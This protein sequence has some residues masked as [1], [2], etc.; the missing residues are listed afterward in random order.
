MAVDSALLQRWLTRL[1]DLPQLAL[2]TDYP[3]PSGE[4]ALSMVEARDERQLDHRTGA[5]LLR[6]A[7]Y[8]EDE[9]ISSDEDEGDRDDPLD[10]RGIHAALEKNGATGRRRD[11]NRPTAFHI[12][13]AAFAV[14]LH[15][16]TGESDIIIA[17][18]SP[19]S[20]EPLLLRIKL[21]PTD[22]FWSLVKSVQFLEAEA[23]ADK[24]SYSELVDALPGYGKEAQKEG[25]IAPPPVFRV[26]FIDQTEAP[27]SS[28]LDSTSLTTDLT[29]FVSTT[30]ADASEGNDSVPASGTATPTSLRTSLAFTPPRIS[31]TLS[32][33]SL[34]FSQPR[35]SL[36]VDQL[37][38]LVHH[39][40]SH[41]QD[42]IGSIS[43]QTSKQ[44]KLLPDP[45]ADLEWCGYRGAITDI[46]SRNARAFPDRT[47]IVESLAPEQF[48]EKNGQRSF[49]YRQVDE[50][51]NVL[52]HHLVQS[53][54]QREEVVTVYSTRGVDLV[55]AVMGV[56]KAG[57][58]FSVIGMPAMPIL[59]RLVC[60]HVRCSNRPGLPSCATDDLPAGRAAPG[61]RYPRCGR[62]ASSARS[63]IRSGEAVDPRRG[64]GPPAHLLR[65]RPWIGRLCRCCGQRR[66]CR[67]A[68][69]GE[70]AAQHPARA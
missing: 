38:H 13:L 53:G 16:Y 24:I 30:P 52:A 55:V 37:L 64:A 54:V 34:I 65:S 2:P 17:T 36:T 29:V 8:D 43:L 10:A 26:R 6:L 23:E 63:A 42:Q 44:R 22:S 11:R 47:C 35:V 31:L 50:A 60:A 49:T 51:S 3:R 15:R 46:F 48:G 39:V 27:D 56:L 68:E 12:L 57:A 59:R 40:S 41:P 20:P 67:R 70:R 45:K 18:S 7:L 19:S 14:L 5:A 66:L 4:N 61:S 32:Y 33:N 69:P 58:T 9:G 21:D 25:G 28:F 62:Q 1:A